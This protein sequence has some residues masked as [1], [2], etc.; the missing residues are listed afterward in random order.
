VRGPWSHDGR[1]WLRT[2][3]RL[4]APALMVFT[5]CALLWA[6]AAG[7]TQP[8]EAYEAKVASDKP[9]AQFRFDDV[10]GSSSVV[11]SVGSFTATNS[12]ISL[13]GEGPFG[14]SRSGSFGGAAYATL[15]GFPLEGDGEFTAEGWV[16]WSGGSTYGEPVFDFGSS[17][18]SY[19]VLSP[20]GASSH[21]LAFEVHGSGKSFQ[22][23]GERKLSG[24][25]WEYVAVTE[26][27]GVLRL[28]L[29]GVEDGKTEG[30]TLTPAS[31]GSA[32]SDY[33][34][35]PLTSGTAL[36]KGLL[37]NVAFYHQALP[38][39]A[40]RE[41]FDDAE[42]PVNTSRPYITGTLKQGKSLSAKA[43]SWSG[44]TPISF[45]YEWER[46]EPGAGGACTP[47]TT[48]SAES[49]YT[50]EN[51]DVG[52]RMRVKAIAGN[53]AGE[54]A[55]TS[56]ETATVEGLKPSNGL[57]PKISGEAKVGQLLSVTEGSWEGTTPFTF[58]YLW[59]H[60]NSEGKSCKSSGGTGSTYRVL[61][62]Q[63]G[64]TLR[65]KVTATNLVGK[66]NATS[67]ITTTIAPG[68]PVNLTPPVLSGAAEDGKALGST[69][70]TWAGSESIS[71]AYQWELCD[72]EGKS[73]NGISGA[74]GSSYMLIPEDIGHTLRM[75]VTAKNSVGSETATST[76]SVVVMPIPPSNTSVPAISGTTVDDQTLYASEGE[77][78]GDQLEYSY[79]W[80]RC[81]EHGE[82]CAPIEGQIEP[83]YE[84]E[85]TESDVGATVRVV[86]TAT[87]AA[88]AV[89][90]TSAATARIG[91]EPPS[92]LQAPSITG[93]SDV[94]Q[95]LYA[96]PGV[97]EG[98]DTQFSYQW[99][100]CS[101]SGTECA[102]VE[103]ATGSE[104]DLAEGDAGSTLRVR[105][106]VG[107]TLGSL[108][109]VSATTPVIGT[110]GALANT[111]A[112]SIS[113][114]P[115]SGDTLGA[116]PGGW[117]DAESLS[118]TY[119][120]QSC[121]RFGEDCEDL[122]GATSSTYTMGPAN[123]GDALR[124]VVS[125][126]DSEH[127]LSLPSSAS[128]PVA[129]ATAPVIEQQPQIEG[130]A[131]A[132]QTLTAG[133]GAWSGEGTISY[134]YQWDRCD[135]AGACSAIEGATASSYTLTEADVNSTV[136]V[137]VEATTSAGGSIAVSS[138]TA[139]IEPEP[140]VRF[141]TPSIAGVVQA[142]SA[143]DAAPGIW[144]GSGQLT[145][146]YQWQSCDPAG[147]ECAPIEGAT[148]STYVVGSGDL[149]STLRVE[150]TASGPLGGASATSA[151]TV[152]VPG[153]E[154][155]V[156]AAQE[157]A[158]T[159]DPAM[160]APSTTATLEEQAITPTLHDTGE[161]LASQST[162]TSSSISKETPGEF[163]V[164]TPSGELSLTP[165]EH[166]ATAT[167]NPTIANEAA[168][169]FANTWPATDTI[170]RAE[171]LG[172]AALLQLRSA[173]AP[174]RFSWEAH[175][176]AGQKLRQL[177]D[178]SVAIVNTPAETELPGES[179]EAKGAP[180]TEEGEAETS[181][182]EAE[183]TDEQAKSEEVEDKGETEVEVPLES[184]PAAPTS[185]PP[186]AEGNPAEPQ[187][188]DTQA[189]YE[190]AGSAMAAA[191]SQTDGQALMVIQAPTVVDAAG[192]SV[193]VS[194][195]VLGDTITMTV[196]PGSGV[197]YPVIAELNVAAPTDK[198]S[199]ERDPVRYGLA[200]DNP[201]TFAKEEGGKLVEEKGK[202][203]NALDPN[204]EKSEAPL[205]V[206]T[207]RLVIPYDVFFNP[208][209]AEATRL[210]NWL[211]AVKGGGLQPY[212]TLGPDTNCQLPAEAKTEA[213]KKRDTQCY[214]PSL[215]RYRA[216]FR[217]LVHDEPGV[218]LWGAWNEPD[219][220]VYPLHHNAPRSARYWQLAQY[221]AEHNSACAGCQVV[222]G[223]FAFATKYEGRYISEYK[224]T[225]AEQHKYPPCD[226]CSHARPGIWGF[227][228]YHDVVYDTG[229]FASKFTQF[230]GGR[231]GKA[232]IWIGEA[233]VELQT[234][235]GSDPTRLAEA[236][237]SN[238]E[239]EERQTQA[240]EDFKSLHSVSTR[241]ER[242]Y[243]Y[244]YRAPTEAEQ[245]KG[246]K[247]K[248]LPFDSGLLEAEP[249]PGM[250]EP[251][252]KG[253][254]RSAYC[255]LAFADGSCKP[256]LKIIHEERVGTS[257][258]V[259]AEV[260]P[261]G[262]ETE[263]YLDYHEDEAPFEEIEK[264][265]VGHGVGFAPAPLRAPCRDGFIQ[266]RIVARNASG[267]VEGPLEEGDCIDE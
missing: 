233:G 124:V 198:V 237:L 192:D 219:F 6:A 55:A 163:A 206:T 200:D 134:T 62:S 241:I 229:A 50:L 72:S 146:A 22:V 235:S 203:V 16:D 94:H 30:V 236:D 258:G 85:L 129:P 175:L 107:S 49:K 267:T 84:Y 90:A 255:A 132:G 82:A 263:A 193:P 191:E 113:G 225:I 53:S 60:C 131:L 240:A 138:A 103:G 36:L 23:V 246:E 228:D 42:F 56:E 61:A 96:D 115:Q 28:Y 148:E 5:V 153:G 133:T 52:D 182:E 147:S 143:L 210:K 128:Q 209:S 29:N 158:Q 10:S 204:L 201:G 81:N 120:W 34:G 105:I 15:P 27:G 164:N 142:G 123:V 17:E 32:S 93:T 260:D 43:G 227:H 195:R 249:N 57:L 221:V 196:N 99:E 244:G 101:S 168:A 261:D 172:A 44:L 156:E 178:G 186:T 24:E 179:Q 167:A 265:S 35:K 257:F 141:S 12:G 252:S 239:Q 58:E 9:V 33:L 21:K 80:E 248:V 2:G 7:G 145:Y 1:S 8:Y 25:S 262:R 197:T 75:T 4:C 222:A 217:D 20:A 194:L 159:T 88:G 59:E 46:C 169:L 130:T 185:S 189:E 76:A 152:V 173:E 215:P 69:N 91:A 166:L 149:G 11:D 83:E 87:N 77:W 74:I 243:Y 40:I 54:G 70:G 19:M 251:K 126:S 92:E 171:P 79:Q 207:A 97:W 226:L 188:Q 86:V 245:Q 165:L 199:A 38:G 211:R 256:S 238:K 162:L 181:A 111:S 102:P 242:I 63:L 230:T 224:N 65:A 205:H 214:V 125:A 104:Y 216:G 64:E 73:C 150:V 39:T 100:S 176:G 174:H 127:S 26:S 117:S 48:V 266:F 31:L 212:I 234:G 177:S 180:A 119:Q 208:A 47:D 259:N 250:S 135:S 253:E 184:L 106:G 223:E 155:S 122:E 264:I 157:V 220:G 41:H 137:I 218:K 151:P 121:N 213:E 160:L 98:T 231:P 247:E 118:Y 136:R 3:V 254:A 67:A 232:Q 161:E 187:P 109:D 144:S 95:V 140:L 112:P 45:L 202:P 14:G 18:S 78:S 154:L 170:L 13:G 51:R 89:R 71:Y 190:M 37:S 68:P 114:A 110:D 66:T 183:A 108:T 139:V 116:S